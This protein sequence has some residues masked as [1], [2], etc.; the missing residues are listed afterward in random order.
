MALKFTTPHKPTSGTELEDSVM[1]AI[2]VSDPS[3]G[4]PSPNYV[5]VQPG[6]LR[7]GSSRVSDPSG[8]RNSPGSPALIETAAEEKFGSLVNTGN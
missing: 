4:L 3:A 7:L 1:R 6:V 2:A 5:D 8:L